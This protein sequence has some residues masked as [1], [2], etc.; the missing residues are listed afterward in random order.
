MTARTR[1]SLA[2][3]LA[4]AA[5]WAPAG[6]G[7]IEHELRLAAAVASD[8]GGTLES[9]TEGRWLG[10][11]LRYGLRLLGPLWAQLGASVESADGRSAA[12][13]SPLRLRLQSVYG[14]LGVRWPRERR[15]QLGLEAGAGNERLREELRP[16]GG[17]GSVSTRVPGTSWHGAASASVEIG[18][19][20]RVPLELRL[21]RSSFD[22]PLGEVGSTRLALGLGVAWRLGGP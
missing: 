6:A 18:R 9:S 12:S 14:A 21:R 2:A 8:T 11:D 17:S 7:A 10:A 22:A 15:W 4:A 13:A 3:A 5:L 20:W 16:R 19:R 1:K